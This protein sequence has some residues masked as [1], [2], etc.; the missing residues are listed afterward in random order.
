MEKIKMKSSVKLVLIGI[1]IFVSFIIMGIFMVQGSQNRA[2]NLEETVIQSKSTINTTLKRRGDLLPNLVDCVKQYDKHEAEVLK[3]TIAARGND[4]SN[5]EL[6][7]LLNAVHEAYPELK[8]N[9]NYNKLMNELAMTENQI[10]AVRN[11]YNSQVKNYNRY[12][13]SFPAR[14]FLSMTGYKMQKFDYLEYAN[15]SED[16]PTNLFD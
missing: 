6:K 1:S 10:L 5:S 3:E 12:V 14:M 8:S 13:K 2:I 16:A 15:V 7:T 11:S 4:F 9:E